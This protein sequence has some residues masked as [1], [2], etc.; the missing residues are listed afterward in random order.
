MSNMFTPEDKKAITV[1]KGSL[2]A[3]YNKKMEEL[4]DGN[5]RSLFYEHCV[6]SGGCIS[7]ILLG[8]KVND[9]DM[10]AKK[11]ITVPIIQKHILEH[12]DMIKTTTDKYGDML[13]PYMTTA[14]QVITGNAI[15]LKNDVQFITMIALDNGAREMFDFIH[16]Q[17][18][19]DISKNSLHISWSQLQSIKQKLLV[20]H[21]SLEKIKPRRVT[22]YEQKGWA[23][24]KEVRDTIFKDVLNLSSATS[25]LAAA[26][27]V[28]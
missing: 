13:Q 26:T 4:K 8:E 21:L 22:K 28:I 12:P 20:P 27:A 18:Y 17:P 9:I 19:Y 2:M 1:A 16:C 10:Y 3:L 5:L 14:P 25:I 15:T 11:A 7:S 6:I 24:D 23:I